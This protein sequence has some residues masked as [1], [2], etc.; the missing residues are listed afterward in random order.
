[1]LNRDFLSKAHR[2]PLSL[3]LPVIFIAMI[4]ILNIASASQATRPDLYLSQLGK[5]IFAFFLMISFAIIDTRVLKRASFLIYGAS[6]FLLLLVLVIGTSAKGAQRWLV[7]GAFRL[8]P[9]DPAKVA[10]I[11]AIASYC[12]NY[13]PIKGYSLMELIK[14]LNI[15]RPIGLFLLAIAV[16]IKSSHGKELIPSHFLTGGLGMGIMATFL[17]VCLSWL[18]LSLYL[19]LR[20]GFYLSNLIAPIDVPLL[21]FLLVFLEPDLATG[22]LL[23]GISGIM[24]LYVGIKR[25]S[26]IFGTACFLIISIGS[27]FTLLKDYQKQRIVS[28]LDQEADAQGKGYQAMQS[29]IAIGSGGFLGKGFSGGTQTQLSF[30]PENST[31]FVFSVWAEEWGFISCLF[32]LFLYFLII[33]SCLKICLKTDDKFSQLVLVGTAANIFIHVAVNV[34]MVT[35]MMPVAGI[36]LPLMSYGGTSMVITMV[37]LG[38]A[39]NVCLWRKT[40]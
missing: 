19:L 21:P 23:L 39:L 29:I 20:Q 28:F 36:P 25:S 40:K 33:S 30:L 3:L 10:I 6:V 17:L 38:L 11:L 34:F 31:D 37:S 32:L 15:S 22:M 13:W 9:S 18:L 1:M 7:F 24:F 35:G 2:V 5:F 26:I 4:G 12:S 8:Q 16:L 27:Y 14:P